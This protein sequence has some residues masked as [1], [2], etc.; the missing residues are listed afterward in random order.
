MTIKQTYDRIRLPEYTGANRCVPCTVLNLAI[1]VAISGLVGLIYL[2]AAVGS[3][4]LLVGIISLRGYLVPG[5]PTL[6]KRYLPDQLLEWFDKDQL[7]AYTVD[8][9]SEIDTDVVPV[10]LGAGALSESPATGDLVMTSTFEAEWHRQIERLDE[11]V[12][13]E[14]MAETLGVD[15]S[16]LSTEEYSQVF[17]LVLDGVQVGRWESR[18]AFQADIAAGVALEGRTDRWAELAIERQ[19][20]LMRALRVFLDRCPDC[21]GA[22]TMEA[23]TVESCCSSKEVLAST[24]QDCGARLFE[25]NAARVKREGS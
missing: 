24:C 12:V 2:P 10:L 4:A 7:T 23:E 13:T 15:G 8:V 3:F 21:G 18:A 22:V 25:L 19:S 17:A 5:T 14:W 16:R 6:T 11:R 1:A 9:D 20:G